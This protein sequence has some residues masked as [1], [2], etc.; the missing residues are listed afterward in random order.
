M[1]NIE[2]VKPKIWNFKVVGGQ[3]AWK[4]VVYSARMSG[5]PEV[6]KDKDVFKMLVENDYG[7][8]L[9][10]IIIKFDLKMSKGN[11]PEF[12]EHRIVSHSGF[13]TRYIKVDEG[14]E[15]QKPMYEVILPLH[16]LSVSQ[17]QEIVGNDKLL[18]GGVDAA[19]NRYQTLLDRKIPREIARYVLPFAQ[20]VG[21]YHVTI[22][23]RSL[24]NF[25]SLRLCVRASPE[26]RCLASQLYFLLLGRLP[27]IQGLVGCRGFMKGVCPESGVTG[28]RT[29]LQHWFY[30]VCPFKN[31]KTAI[32][33]PTKKEMRKGLSLKEFDKD[34]AMIVQ[35]KLFMQWARWE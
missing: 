28:V 14:I 13:S 3:D 11:A 16:L 26:M 32:C 15:K 35:E 24:L 19:I 6:V 2:I 7:S 21:I 17:L 27:E 10:H 33:I 5:V 31:R 25:L 9:E 12:L 34:M 4:E 22:N 18:K 1:V 30:P 29:G 8:A 20:A 23:L